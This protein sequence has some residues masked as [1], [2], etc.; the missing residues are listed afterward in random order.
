MTRIKIL[1]T[2]V[3][4]T[5][6]LATQIMVVGAAPATQE[7]PPITGT[8]V[9]ITLETDPETEVTTVLVTLD[10]GT[11][12]Y[13][14]V[15]LSLEDAIDLGLINED[16]TV[17]E[18]AKGTPVE[19]DPSIVLPDAPEEPVE[20]NL[21]PVGSAL[22]DFFSD[23]L[24]VD[25]ETIM[26]YHE[27]GVGFGVIAQALWMTNALDGDSEIFAAILDA[28]Q[29][30]DFSGITLPDGSTPQNW[31]QFRK[32]LLKDPEK[33]KQNLGVIMS[34]HADDTP[35][36]ETPTVPGNGNANPPGHDKDKNKDKDHG[37]GKDKDKDK[38]KNK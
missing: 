38:G 10:V 21:H 29:N 13:E 28:R 14:T 16:G 2:L 37:N 34:G 25:Y 7:T 11:E 8:V 6:F 27:E 15:R 18:D 33:A 4:A 19:I 9:D 24:G 22:S 17:N 31:G 20:E 35:G 30:H 3:L 1:S 5:I 32:A 12:S 26:E 36:D 23:L